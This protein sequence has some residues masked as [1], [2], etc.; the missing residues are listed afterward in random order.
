MFPDWVGCD[1][2]KRKK[3][4]KMFNV[5]KKFIDEVNNG[6]NGCEIMLNT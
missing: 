3:E 4:K 5:I 1:I 6:C 2:D